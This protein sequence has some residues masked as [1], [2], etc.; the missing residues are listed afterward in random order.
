MTQKNKERAMNAVKQ[1][2]A[3]ST[4]NI[5]AGFQELFEQLK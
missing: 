4:T 3:E 2:G 1:L 5:I